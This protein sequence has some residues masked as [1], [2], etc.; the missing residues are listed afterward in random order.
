M[1]CVFVSF[2]KCVFYRLLVKNK[3]ESVMQKLPTIC[4]FTQCGKQ[5]ALGIATILVNQT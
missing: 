4:Y 3:N 1:A 5:C 2:M